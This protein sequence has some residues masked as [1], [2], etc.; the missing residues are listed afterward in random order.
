MADQLDYI[1][2]RTLHTVQSFTPVLNLDDSKDPQ[3]LKALTLEV[4]VFLVLLS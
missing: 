1:N 3:S 2:E 4:K